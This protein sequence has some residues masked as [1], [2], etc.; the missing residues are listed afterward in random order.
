MRKNFTVLVV[1]L[2]AVLVATPALAAI[3]FKWGGQFR[4]RWIGETNI[5]DGSDDFV[6][7]DNFIDQRLRLYFTVTASENL[8]L[9]VK[10]EMGDTVWGDPRARL[11][12]G[13]GGGVGADGVNVELKNAYIDFAI[14]CTPTRALIG[15]QGL[16]LLD[17]WIIDDDFSA[18]VLVTKLDPFKITLG[19]VAGQNTRDSSGDYAYYRDN[20]DDWFLAIDYACGPWKVNLTG[21]YQYAHQVPA[22]V[23]PDTLVTPAEEQ[24]PGGAN[25]TPPAGSNRAFAFNALQRPFIGNGRGV[26][27]VE[28][29]A[30]DALFDN[31]GVVDV[32]NDVAAFNLFNRPVFNVSANNF[33]DL[34]FRLEYKVDWL[35]A[36]VNFVKNFGSV[37]LGT[38]DYVAVIARGFDDFGFPTFGTNVNS[39]VYGGNPALKS[40]DYTGWMVDAGVFYYCGPFTLNLGGFYTTGP[41]YRKYTLP[42]V[43][44]DNGD[45]VRDDFGN[46]LAVNWKALDVQSDV[47]WF[48][49]PHAGPSKQSSEIVGGAVFDTGFF[50]GSFGKDGVNYWIGYPAPSNLWTINIGGAWQVL[51]KTKLAAS[52]WYWA[53]S[54]DVMSGAKI[55]TTLINGIPRSI[56]VGQEFANDV[57][58]ELNFNMTQGIVDGL[59]LDLVAAYMFTGDAY[60]NSW[61]GRFLDAENFSKDDAWKLGA[62]LQ[63]N[64]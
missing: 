43:R 44:V 36:Y 61:N 60:V 32:N 37:E 58:Y 28:F 26:R 30:V 23:F 31:I 52:F 41:D 14:P 40:L 10:W 34:G 5:K 48:T 13:S 49:Y 27:F 51:P 1:L 50:P 3:D 2:M 9:V 18:A 35:K 42:V 38:E 25:L 59:T 29:D 63:W 12:A 4:V 55:G 19:Y 33:F 21:F 17:S 15:I 11:G 53:T 64:F 46:I 39:F 56:L 8:K 57:G 62:R 20:V 6:D 54:E 47:S 24:W 16:Q 7:R 45:F 22:S